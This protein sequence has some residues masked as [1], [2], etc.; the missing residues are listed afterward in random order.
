MPSKMALP[1]ASQTRSGVLRP[2]VLTIRPLEMKRLLTSIAERSNPPGLN[3]KSRT[4]PRTLRRLRSSSA[5]AQLLGRFLAEGADADVADLALLVVHEFPVVVGLAAIAQH[6]FHVDPLAREREFLALRL[7]RMND[8]DRDLGAFGPFHP[9]NRVVGLDAVGAL[10]LDL[11]DPIAGLDARS[12]GG[13]AIDG[14]EDLQ[15]AVIDRNVNADA[16]EFVVH[17]AAELGQLLRA[18]VGRVGIELA[19]HAADGGLDQLAAI[20]LFDVVSIDL[21]DRVGQQLDR[22]RSSRPWAGAGF[23]LRALFPRSWRFRR[24]RPSRGKANGSEAALKP[25]AETTYGTSW[26]IGFRKGKKRWDLLKLYRGLP[27]GA[28]KGKMM[29][30][31]RWI[32]TST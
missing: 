26:G 29:D 32:F 30:A 8:G 25:R 3:R 17:R 19:H 4:R 5:V 11:D 24:S 18:D 21:I 12:I 13:R 2:L 10:A 28:R 23:F 6:G 27:F 9:A 31:K 20:D 7:A 1:W 16:A 22:A 15:I 14:A